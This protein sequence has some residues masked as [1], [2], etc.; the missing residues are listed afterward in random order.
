MEELACCD[1]DGVDRLRAAVSAASGVAPSAIGGA[2]QAVSAASAAIQ[3]Q[4]SALQAMRVAES[5]IPDNQARV[6][7]LD[8]E[9]RRKTGELRA[10]QQALA[11]LGELKAVADA[12]EA[13]RASVDSTL[14]E[15]SSLARDVARGG[16]PSASIRTESTSFSERR[17]ALDQLAQRT[18][19]GRGNLPPMDPFQSPGPSDPRLHIKPTD[20][21]WWNEEF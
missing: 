6:R 8:E 2:T 1:P 7:Q 14:G 9:L 3:A 13:G 16:M 17:S 21:S 20:T 18:P 5:M 12:L 11:K 15:V 4:V 10:A 19:G